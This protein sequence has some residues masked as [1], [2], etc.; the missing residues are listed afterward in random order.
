M[1]V[2]EGLNE[3]VGVVAAVNLVCNSEADAPS[4]NRRYV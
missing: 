4:F 3:V 2:C 1:D